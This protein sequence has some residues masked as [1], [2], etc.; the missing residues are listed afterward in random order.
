MGRGRNSDW[1]WRTVATARPSTGHPWLR[2]PDATAFQAAGAA[3]RAAKLSAD[4]KERQRAA[5]IVNG[6]GYGRWDEH[7]NWLR[8]DP[9][10]RRPYSGADGHDSTHM[11]VV[12][13]SELSAEE[14]LARS[15]A[16]AAVEAYTRRTLQL[17]SNHSITLADLQRICTRSPATEGRTELIEAIFD[18]AELAQAIVAAEEAASLPSANV[19]A[20]K[21]LV[22]RTRT[23]M[24][25][26]G[27]ATFGDANL[28]NATES[29]SKRLRRSARI[30]AR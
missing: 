1:F 23:K 15:G 8:G 28:S 5:G 13:S 9:G 21:Q 30:A 17:T 7:G 22:A 12:G 2:D 18:S 20:R 26:F 27:D 10:K 19:A 29:A 4:W 3:G 24:D 6:R 25:T 11:A 14:H 16:E